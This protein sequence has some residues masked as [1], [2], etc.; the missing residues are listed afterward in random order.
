M[1]NLKYLLIPSI[2]LVI[3]IVWTILVKTVDVQYI[4]DI[5][6]LGFYNFN[7]SLDNSIQTLNTDLFHKVTHVLLF[8]ALATIIPF[9]VLGLIQLI[10]RK[11]LK[12]VDPVLYLLLTSYVLVVIFYFIF[13]LV[14]I[15]FSPLSTKND[16]HAS[17]PSSHV[18]IF[19]AVM[20]VNLYGLFHYIKMSKTLKIIAVCGVFALMTAMGVLRLLSGRHYFTD[21][22]GALFLSVTILTIFDSLTKFF[23][24]DKKTE[25][26]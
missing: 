4:Q 7:T 13:E 10:K 21:I 23:I 26:E 11:S 24:K 6:F 22:V 9:A 14:K 19:I 5:G 18:F 3:F 2:A 16:L 12:K 25:E 15:N 8:L 17:Y 20:G 1:K